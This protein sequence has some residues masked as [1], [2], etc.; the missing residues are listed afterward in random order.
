[1]ITRSVNTFIIVTLTFTVGAKMGGMGRSGLFV[2]W[3]RKGRQNAPD[4]AGASYSA[5]VL[6]SSE[7]ILSKGLRSKES[8]GSFQPI[9]GTG[10]RGSPKRR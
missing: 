7:G 8:E 3:E 9:K 5:R 4:S 6:T 1:M 2:G 10:K